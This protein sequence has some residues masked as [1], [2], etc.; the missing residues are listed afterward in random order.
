[1]NE[2]DVAKT[3]AH[4]FYTIVGQKA[5]FMLMTLRETMEELQ[6]FET[7]DCRLH[8]PEV[9]LRFSIRNYADNEKITAFL[10]I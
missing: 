9:F 6:E 7:D 5:D 8:N 2:A 1:M 4:A 10:A 3:G